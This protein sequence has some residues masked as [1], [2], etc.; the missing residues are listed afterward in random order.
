VAKQPDL[1]DLLKQAQQMQERLLSAQAAAADTVVEGHAG[2][3]AVRV[4]VT[5]TLEF[6]AVHIDPKVVD[7]DDVEIL[8]D[9]IL[10]ALH[11]ATAKAHELS[12]Q[13]MG[14]MPDIGGLGGLL[15][16]G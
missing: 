9:L 8:E 14:G 13:A 3:G 7:A 12:A 1:S 15:S 5:G 11:D 10:A 2:G 6:R 4:E 16:P